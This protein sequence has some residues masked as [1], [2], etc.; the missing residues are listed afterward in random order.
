[1]YQYKDQSIDQVKFEAKQQEDKTW[2]VKFPH[3]DNELVYSDE[4]FNKNFEEV[5]DEIK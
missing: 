2:V 3:Q 5:A 4:D 1:M